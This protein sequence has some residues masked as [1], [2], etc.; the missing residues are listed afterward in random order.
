MSWS[1]AASRGAGVHTRLRTR[2]PGPRF[3]HT[4]PNQT[5]NR[6]KQDTERVVEQRGTA[7]SFESIRLHFIPCN[8]SS[9][10]CHNQSV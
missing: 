8:T 3:A 10:T 4:R 5:L 7:I 1:T 6:G 9:N 2:R